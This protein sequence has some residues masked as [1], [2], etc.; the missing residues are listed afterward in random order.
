MK[1]TVYGT[2]SDL[3]KIVKRARS[4]GYDQVEL[5]EL[6]YTVYKAVSDLSSDHYRPWKS[7]IV[8]SWYRDY[9][10]SPKTFKERMCRLIVVRNVDSIQTR[11]NTL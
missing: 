2:F 8:E 7:R 5:D 3:M 9:R 10:N 11:K 6:D 1:R 4:L